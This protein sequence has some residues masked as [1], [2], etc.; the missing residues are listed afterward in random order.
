MGGSQ[1]AAYSGGGGGTAA[2]SATIAG[3]SSYAPS[4]PSSGAP[5]AH[6]AE[7][8]YEPARPSTQ[9]TIVQND[10]VP[11]RPGLGLTLSK[12]ALA[13]WQVA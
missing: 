11:D 8:F 5:P 1:K 10:P 12:D 7:S 4:G 9:S 6:A 13:R 3:D 2:P